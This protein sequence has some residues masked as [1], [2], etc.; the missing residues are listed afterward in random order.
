MQRSQ[1]SL[2]V[3]ASGLAL[4][5]N[6]V[7]GLEDVNLKPGG[8]GR[9]GGGGMSAAGKSGE[10]M[11]AA[12]GDP[13]N[14]GA[15]NDGGTAGSGT[16]GASGSGGK[17]GTG[18]ASGSG[19]KGGTGT[20]GGAGSQSGPVCGDGVV[21]S[22][23]TC[24][25]ENRGPG[26][27]CGD[28]CRVE[29]GWTC[30]GADPTS[31]EEVC[32]D[33][34]LVGREALAG[35]CDD[36]DTESGDG[37]SASC[38]VEVDDGWFCTGTPSI[39]AQTCGNG[40]VDE[41]EECDDM[42]ALPDDGCF[43]CVEEVG[44]DCMQE[45][46]MCADVDE[47]ADD[48]CENGGACT[49][50]T[51]S[52]SC[53]C[54]GTGYSGTTC[55][56]DV[57][58]C[59]GAPCENGGVCTNTAGSFSCDCAGTGYSGTACEND[60]NECMSN[61]D[62]CDPNATCTNTDGSFTCACGGAYI[63]DGTSCRLPTIAELTGA[64]DGHVL[65]VPCGDTPN[66][67]DCNS[68]G[69]RST[70]VNNSALNLCQTGRFE[71][72][73]TFPVGGQPGAMYDVTMHFYGIME[74]RRYSN[75]TREAGTGATNR[76][77]GTPT[78]WAEAAGSADPYALGDANYNTYEMRVL[79]QNGTVIRQ[80]FLNS[81]SGTG[82]YTFIT[83]YV[84]TVTLVGGGQVR[85]RSYDANCRIIKNCGANGGTNCTGMARTVDITA[86]SP[87]PPAN[88]L[89]QPGL[90]QAEPHS[91]QWWMIDVTNVAAP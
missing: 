78:G 30:D 88:T 49:N 24:D 56:T 57:D 66:T 33:G 59:A 31:C 47:C 10:G 60:V 32:G 34:Q 23:E 43:A 71:A 81:D 84:K 74:P 27:G 65:V 50:T 29:S 7:L 86:A 38:G 83:N 41:G 82:H 51:G 9:G 28:T 44:W 58:E 91:G 64:L 79:D 15:P 11:G 22:G 17:A 68:A 5:C 76:T 54:A 48:P 25:D 63:G 61:M 46:S 37:C 18:A 39:C 53:D 52:F 62:D 21:D 8:A 16:G 26:D 75:V 40:A 3:G 45:P 19:G 36:D 67:D 69:W 6:A 90:G 72:L 13:V 4:A 87:Q 55:Q 73:I 85:L 42:N 20:G 77:G 35:G 1:W 89:M 80:Y 2:L 70:A 14:G 12:G